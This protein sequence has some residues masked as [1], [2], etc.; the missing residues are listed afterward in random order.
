[1]NRLVNFAIPS[2]LLLAHVT[3][4]STTP[5]SFPVDSVGVERKD[6][7]RFVLHRVDQGQ[8]LYAVARRYNSTVDAIKSANPDLTDN[9]VRYDQL[10]R[11]PVADVTLSRKEQRDAE[12]AL[13]KEEKEK[14]KVAKE[15]E[16]VTA[17][18]IKN[19]LRP[20]TKAKPKPEK[21]A[22]KPV[23][24]RPTGPSTTG[25]HVVETGQTLYS[26]AVRY[27]VTMADIRDL[28]VMTQADAK[29]I[30]FAGFN[31]VPHKVI[32]LPDGPFTISA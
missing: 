25:I 21:V 19:A 1:M 3:Y 32:D 20:D 28:P 30:G 22:E 18:D 7:K 5:P 24:S 2:L 31:N 13:K 29:A 11:V 10:L 16:E 15:A 12:K 9:S 4:A 6:G 17:E 14:Q 26:L 23:S 8:T 27:S